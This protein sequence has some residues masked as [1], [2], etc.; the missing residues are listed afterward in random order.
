MKSS[1]VSVQRKKHNEDL[2]N[3]MKQGESLQSQSA[4]DSWFPPRP[5]IKK[6][7][8]ALREL[9]VPDQL[10]EEEFANSAHSEEVNK[11]NHLRLA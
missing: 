4:S 5:V 10:S 6:N 2:I 1:K 8:A 3:R 11:I 9:Y 7:S